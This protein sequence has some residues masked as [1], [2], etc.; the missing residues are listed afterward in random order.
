[1]QV[2]VF[3]ICLICLISILLSTMILLRKHFA[4]PRRLFLYYVGDN[5]DMT[6]L[7]DDDLKILTKSFNENT[8]MNI[9]VCVRGTHW[10]TNIGSRGFR[11][12]TTPYTDFC[13]FLKM[14]VSASTIVWYS[15][16]SFSFYV[17]PSAHEYIPIHQI[18]HTIEQT[19]HVVD[20]MVFDSCGMASIECATEFSGVVKYMVACEGYGAN[21]GFL[22]PH[23]LSTLQSSKSV[24]EIG[25]SLI[26]QVDGVP[27][28]E[29][30]NASLISLSS[31]SLSTK[32]PRTFANFVYPSFPLVDLGSTPSVVRFFRQT[33]ADPPTNHGLSILG[34]CNRDMIELYKTCRFSRLSGYVPA[35][36]DLRVMTINLQGSGKILEWCKEWEEA[37]AD[38]VLVQEITIEDVKILNAMKNTIRV[39]SFDEKWGTAVIW[40]STLQKIKVECLLSVHLNDLPAPLHL[41]YG[42]PYEGQREI[43]MD[44]ILHECSQSRL[45]ELFSLMSSPFA[46]VGGDFNEP[47]HLDFND[48]E[49]PV[50]S[51]LYQMGYVDVMQNFQREITWPRSP[52]Y[53]RDP[54]Q[55]IDMIYVRSDK[56]DVVYAG[57]YEF[58]NRLSDHY[59][60]VC[61]L[62]L[63]SK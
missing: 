24:E 1:M 37:E 33:A 56:W 3:C 52:F 38:V 57:R 9:V 34:R 61:D 13:T 27:E 11:H 12:F 62:R 55:R 29:K 6:H 45:P 43:A 26:E 14:Y 60:V 15:G 2:D 58:T 10:Y 59:G 40:M 18:R 8:S 44:D 17:H 25:K 41:L 46:I 23:T 20:L 42:I 53:Q 16:H 36:Y 35:I 63:K 48:I 50:S 49:W 5:H 51:T 30:W 21:R 19:G 54:D 7:I 39:Q 31:L 32:I 4:K 28:T 22:T 47:S